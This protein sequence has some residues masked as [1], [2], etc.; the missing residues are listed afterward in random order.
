MI[1]AKRVSSCYLAALDDTLGMIYISLRS[2]HLH[3]LEVWMNDLTATR[4]VKEGRVNDRLQLVK[5]V[6]GRNEGME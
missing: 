6:E 2:L 1:L 3:L 4:G 5:R